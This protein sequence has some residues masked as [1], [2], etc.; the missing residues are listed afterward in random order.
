MGPKRALRS[1]EGSMR[2]ISGSSLARWILI[3]ARGHELMTTREPG[4]RPHDEVALLRA[5]TARHWVH[6]PDARRQYGGAS[7]INKIYLKKLRLK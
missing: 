4:H 5:E 1:Y 7:L 2:N 6:M 3:A